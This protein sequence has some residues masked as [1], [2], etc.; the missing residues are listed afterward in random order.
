MWPFNVFLIWHSGKMWIWIKYYNYRN[1]RKT[2]QAWKI[3]WI[4]LCFIKLRCR[5]SLS[6]VPGCCMFS[7]LCPLCV[8]RA[9]TTCGRMQWCSRSSACVP[10]CCSAT[11][12]LARGSSTSDDTRLHTLLTR[13]SSFSFK[14]NNKSRPCCIFPLIFMFWTCNSPC[15][16]EIKQHSIWKCSSLLWYER[17]SYFL[18]YLIPGGAFLAA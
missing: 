17:L 12:T 14:E 16:L 9:R 18:S 15:F 4:A 7:D 10:C 13:L 8:N 1:H 2:F 5:I 3:R 6:M 11:R